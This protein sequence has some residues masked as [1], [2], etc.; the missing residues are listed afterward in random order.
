M[1][2]KL[3]RCTVCTWRGLADDARIAR[4]V[5]RPSDIPPAMLEHQEVYEEIRAAHGL[6][7]CPSCGHHLTPVLKHRRKGSIHP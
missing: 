4:P 2:S 7:R 1:S 3:V 6:P 5:E